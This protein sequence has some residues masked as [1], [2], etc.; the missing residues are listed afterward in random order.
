MWP[1]EARQGRGSPVRPWRQPRV[2]ACSVSRACVSV[3]TKDLGALIDAFDYHD[4][5]FPG[6][7]QNSQMYCMDHLQFL[8][9]V[10]IAG[11]ARE[12]ARI[13]CIHTMEENPKP[14]FY[15]V[16]PPSPFT[17]TPIRLS[18]ACRVLRIEV[19]GCHGGGQVR[20]CLRGPP[21]PSHPTHPLALFT[22]R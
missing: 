14:H 2:C 4:D 11:R 19:K 5:S 17:G 13:M 3:I 8:P 22:A 10:P 7:F 21:A 12:A 18:P 1:V 15:R 6:A 16:R 9:L 20:C